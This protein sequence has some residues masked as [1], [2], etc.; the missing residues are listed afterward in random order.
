MKTVATLSALLALLPSLALAQAPSAEARFAMIDA[1]T[2]IAAGADRHQWDRLREAF[3][4]RVTLD[5]T[6]LWGGEVETKAA[7]DVVA[8][9]S[10]FLP[11]FDNTLHL[12]TNHTVTSFDGQTATMQA[13][14][15][16]AHRIDRDHW[17]L[18]GHYRYGLERS[19]G[20]WRVHSLT[21]DWTHETGD[22]GLAGRAAERAA[23]AQ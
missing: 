1:V 17:V 23:K 21:M 4:D 14:F 16:A 11:G 15:Q 10:A 6:S 22:R 20:Q 5:Y 9:W 2:S 7:D 19:G 13:D 18:S 12:V 8:Q 3:S